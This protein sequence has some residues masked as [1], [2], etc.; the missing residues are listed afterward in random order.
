MNIDTCSVLASVDDTLAKASKYYLTFGVM[1]NF[2]GSI[3]NLGEATARILIGLKIFL[4]NFAVSNSRLG[5]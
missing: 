5:L 1:V 2:D 4:S 3:L